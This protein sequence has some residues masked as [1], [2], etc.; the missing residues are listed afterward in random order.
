VVVNVEKIEGLLVK[1]YPLEKK[2]RAHRSTGRKLKRGKKGR[3]GCSHGKDL[4]GRFQATRKKK[5]KEEVKSPAH[6]GGGLAFE[7]EN[8][9]TQQVPPISWE[10]GGILSVSRMEK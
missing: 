7:A 10:A 3:D 8:V 1:S 9:K 6:K 5:V 2:N 4:R